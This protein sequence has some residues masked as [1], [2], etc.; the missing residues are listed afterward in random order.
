MIP[1]EHFKL[2]AE[3]NTDLDTG[4]L[5][6]VLHQICHATDKLIQHNSET[7]IDLNAM[8][9]APG[10]KERLKATLGR[11]EISIQ[12]NVL[13]RS[14]LYETQ[15]AGVWWIEHYNSNDNLMAQLIEINWLPAIAR[16]QAEDVHAGLHK[17]KAFFIQHN[18]DD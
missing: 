3:P 9:F 18:G 4:N 12:L 6:P 11:G 2:N 1:T 5:L 14:E 8:P 15:Y 10:E 13:G 16:S 17:M 7:L